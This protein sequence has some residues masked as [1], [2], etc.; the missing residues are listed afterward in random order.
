MGMQEMILAYTLKTIPAHGF[1]FSCIFFLFS[2][3]F[4]SLLANARWFFLLC[5]TIFLF[6][7]RVY[8]DLIA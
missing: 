6:F 7:F 4:V 2:L 5:A 3:L 8:S 1:A